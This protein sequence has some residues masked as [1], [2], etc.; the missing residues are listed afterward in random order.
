MM[1]KSNK[2]KTPQTT[3]PLK[4]PSSAAPVSAYR[5]KSVDSPTY[6]TRSRSRS[7]SESDSS[8]GKGYIVSTPKTANLLQVSI[9]NQSAISP[10]A[11]ELSA[12]DVN[13]EGS[14]STRPKP[15]K[16]VKS[17][18]PCNISSKGEEWLLHCTKCSQH[19]HP[20]CA[21]LKSTT[22]LPEATI[23]SISPFWECPWCFTPS[24]AC[25]KNHR[26]AKLSQSLA[27][28]TSA[29]EISSTVITALESMIPNKLSELFSP[30]NDLMKGIQSQL[31][32]LS[33][34]V[35]AFLKAPRH[36]LPHP[37]GPCPPPSLSHR[38]TGQPPAPPNVRTS[39][40]KIED[41]SSVNLPHSTMYIERMMENY[42]NE[43][44]EKELLDF[45]EGEEFTTEGQRSVLQ[46]GEHYKYMGSKTSPKQMPDPIS[47]ILKRINNEYGSKHDDDR[48]NFELN[49]CLVNRY[50]SN[51]SSLPEHADDE[52][53]IDPKSCIATLSIGAP[54]N[55]TFRELGTNEK[56]KLPCNSRSMYLM[57]RH[58]QNFFKHSME[59]EED[60]PDG[61][62]YSL[63]FR[64]VHWSNFN[65]T[66]LVGDSNFGK[67]RF[68]V[69][70]GKVGAAT[71]GKREWA[72]TVNAIDPLKCSSYRNVVFM[73]GTND[74]KNRISDEQIRSVYKEYKTKISLVR[75][76]NSK[77]RILV[78]P[79]LPTKSH[80][81]NRRINIFNQLIM[82][83]LT[84][85]DLRVIPVLGMIEFLDKRTNLLS[86]KLS[87]DNDTLH[88]NGRGVGLLVGLIK[89]AIF[90]TRRRSMVNSPRTYSN[91][92][93]GGPHHPV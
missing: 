82:S 60:L 20:P 18:C 87:L 40:V 2:F 86:S 81:I 57:S 1:N 49:S 30:T 66:L 78:C 5:R 19:W 22:P 35:N 21:N 3:K 92:V 6:A 39:P 7:K 83:D 45:L 4:T 71:P 15:G 74:L 32:E 91:A 69:G 67:V 23:I 51:M 41:I 59:P 44:E 34:N 90:R 16:T 62:R 43:E 52:G 58:S 29:N 13:S 9:T 11:S 33:E 46:Y 55:I 53:D 70:K 68:G 47:K 72:P 73:V 89:E 65:S 8:N 85:C 38:P 64:A 17:K 26:S 61:V 75:K 79:V 63:T 50:H 84:Q 27:T 31:S 10:L 14:S 54:R 36:P 77:C 48:D 12:S 25:P 37:P 24:F 88:L 28:T 56:T 42:I 76:Y 80:E 93:R